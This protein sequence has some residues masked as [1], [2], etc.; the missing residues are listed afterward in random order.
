MLGLFVR[1]YFYLV[2]SAIGQMILSTTGHEVG[3]LAVGKLYGF[4]GIIRLHI[5]GGGIER[6]AGVV[7]PWPVWAAGGLV[8]GALILL[9]FWLV[10]FV[11]PT[12]RDFYIEYAAVCVAFGHFAYAW[13]EVGVAG[14]PWWPIPLVLT[15]AAWL[16][17][18]YLYLPKLVGWWGARL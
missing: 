7:A 3:H 5:F 10:P 6:D 15:V 16:S 12:I 17:I 1:R 18:T 4:E 2:W 8:G 11:T 9:F 14:E 13:A